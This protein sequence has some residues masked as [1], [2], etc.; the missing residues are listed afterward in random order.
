MYASE[1]WALKENTAWLKKMDSI[2]YVYISWTVH[3]TCMIYI[4]FEK[5]GPKIFKY[6]RRSA[7]LAHSR[8]VTS[9]ESKMATMQHK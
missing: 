1:T 9:V 5:E 8:A 3:G 6:H 2:S 7:R 4:I